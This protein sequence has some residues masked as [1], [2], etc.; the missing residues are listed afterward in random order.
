[1]TVPSRAGTRS[2]GGPPSGSP[3]RCYRVADGRFPLLDG[4]GAAR[5]GG[6]WNSPGQRVVYA[7]LSYANALLEILA[8]RS[9]AQLPP[10]YVWLTL[11]V[12]AGVKVAVADPTRIPGWDAPD[13]VA[14][15]V[16]GNAWLDAGQTVALMVPAKP[17]APHEWNAVFNPAHPEFARVAVGAPELVAWDRRLWR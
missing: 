15:R 13:E 17:A 10:G 6:R 12:P 5:I 3:F 4:A 7:S 9:R 8:H 2:P 16:A 1:M 14:A 11:D